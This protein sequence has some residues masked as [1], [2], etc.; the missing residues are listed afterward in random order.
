MVPFVW[1]FYAF[2]LFMI[3]V[4]AYAWNFV[5]VTVTVTQQYAVSDL[6]YNPLWLPEACQVVSTAVK[7]TR[8]QPQLQHFTRFFSAF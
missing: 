7:T 2:R 3:F 5:T 6:Y 8:R 1:G 4:C